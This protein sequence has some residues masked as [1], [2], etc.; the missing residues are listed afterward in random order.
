MECF[1]PWSY[2][3]TSGKPLAVGEQFTFGIEGLWGNHDGTSSSH[4]LADGIK[5]ESVNRIFMFRARNGWGRAVISATG[6]S[7]ISDEQRQLQRD[8][9]KRFQDYDTYGS[10]PIAYQLAAK[11]DVTIAIDDAKGRRVRN[12]FGQYPRDAGAVTDRWDAVDDQ[13]NPVPPG[14]YTATVLHHRPVALK[15]FNSVY[16]SAT[17]PWPTEKG[18]LLWG[19]N[20][21]HPTSVATRGDVTVLFFTGTEGGSGVQRIDDRGIIQWADGQEFLAGA[22]SERFVYGLSRSA[23]QRKTL[24]FRYDVK[25][26]QLTPFGDA[27]RSPSAQLFDDAE[28]ADG[29]M[30][31]AH[32]SLWALFPGRDALLRI[33]GETGAILETMP[34]GDLV[35]IAESGGKAYVLAKNGALAGLDAAGRA[36]TPFATVAGLKDPKRLAV[37]PQGARFLIS[38]HGTNQVVLCDRSGKELR[39]FGRAY[40]GEDRPAGPFVA[41]DLIRPMGTGFDH[42][43]RIWIPEGVKNCKRVGLWNADGALIDQ[44]WG[45]ADYGAT[46]GWPITHDSTR[47]IAHGIEFRLDPQP[48]PWKRK[49]AEQPL[50][51]HPALDHERGLVYRVDGRDYAC[52]SPGFNK[53]KS[54]TIFRR[55]ERQCFV[56][57]VRLEVGT[58]TPGGKGKPDQI[59]PATAWVD[60]N[61]DGQ[62]SDDELTAIAYQPFDQ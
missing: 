37:D 13:G 39:R 27:A 41:T 11:S 28:V 19:S 56:P 58:K 44:F 62:Q 24:I 48:D 6:G 16:S 20:H 10:V 31:I 14:E 12:L 1:W 9:L 55:D 35:G 34:A 46:S 59:T 18:T 26:G 3:R 33:D 32:G 7:K 23:W 40:E 36:G 42:L 57:C 5:D 52:G 2:C 54:L 60:R 49:T 38:D 21:G 25:T 51:F 22:I 61:A 43:G 45:Q 29:S 8:R 47:F 4:R 50:I 30:V 53:M 15:L 17:P